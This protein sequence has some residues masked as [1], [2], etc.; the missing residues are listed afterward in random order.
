MPLFRSYWLILIVDW[1]RRDK[2]NRQQMIE[3]LRII[4]I[5]SGG[6]GRGKDCVFLGGSVPPSKSQ[7]SCL[8]EPWPIT[9]LQTNFYFFF[10]VLYMYHNL[11]SISMPRAISG[12]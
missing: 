6:L 4:Y 3:T 10:L 9:L 11:F 12:T 1:Y 8:C 7:R 2:E 5:T